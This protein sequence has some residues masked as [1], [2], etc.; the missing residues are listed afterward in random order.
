MSN[1]VC[2]PIWQYLLWNK[3]K[4]KSSYDYF[5]HHLN[6]IYNVFMKSDNPLKEY[7]NSSI[8]NINILV[9]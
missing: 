1:T 9:Y 4:S 8:K 7:L 5:H 6:R 2:H 3:N